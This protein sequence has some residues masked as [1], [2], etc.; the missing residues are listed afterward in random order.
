MKTII[1]LLCISLFLGS[2]T[3]YAQSLAVNTTGA[4]ANSSSILDVSSGSKGILIPRMSSVQRMGIGT[5]ANGL[6]VYDIDSSAFSY[7]NGAVWSFL[8]A[9]VDTA[10][11]WNTK[12]NN[13]ITPANFLGTV[14]DA[15]LFF[16]RNTINA[17]YIKS[18]NTAFGVLSGN[19]GTGTNNTAFGYANLG[20]NTTGSFNT[21][22]GARN[23]EYSTGDYN[24]AIGAFNLSKT[25]QAGQNY[26]KNVAIGYGAMQNQI[27][28]RSNI[29]IGEA[30]LNTDT[31]S[32]N[33]IAIGYKALFNNANK[34]NL[35]AIGDSALYN[36][37][38]GSASV[39][40][41]ADNT[42]LG[43]KTLSGNTIGYGNTAT[44]KSAL[45]ANINGGLNVA[46]GAYTLFFNT[47]GN[48]N[49]AVGSGAQYKN[50]TGNSNTAVGDGTL[51]QN[52]V[53]YSNVAIGISALYNNTT[54]S[55]LVAIGDSA[56][57]NNG[58]G[59][60]I[61]YDGAFNTAIGSKALFKNTTGNS[62]TATGN[63]SLYNNITGND[64]TANGVNALASNTIGASNTANGSSALVNNTNGNSNTANGSSALAGNT[65]GTSNTASGAGALLS[66]TSGNYNTANGVFSM[67]DNLTG[68]HNT[69]IGVNALYRNKR[70]NFNT[71]IGDSSLFTDTVSNNTALGAYTLAA[72]VRGTNNVAVGVK[73]GNDPAND[74]GYYNTYIGDSTMMLANRTNS[75]VIGSKA[76]TST[77]NSMVLGSING[78][79]GATADVKI[80]IGVTDP[81]EKLEIGNGRLRFRGNAPFGNAH[82]ITWTNNAGTTDR[83]FIGMETDNFWG[84]YSFG[85]G[86][87]VRVHNTTGE[88]GVF[89]QPLTTVNDSRLQVK[90][91]G[92]QNGIGIENTNTTNH[93]DL[94]L[95]AGAVP[96]FNF[97][98][99]GSLRS[100]IRNSDGAYIQ[101]SDK[102][103]KKDITVLQPALQKISTLQPYQYHYVENNAGSNYSI[104]FMAQ[105]VQ[106][107]FPDAVSEKLMKDGRLQLGVNYQY[108]TVLAIKGLQEQQSNMEAQNKKIEVLER[109]LAEL[110]KLVEQ[111]LKN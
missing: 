32:F 101:V 70:G 23:I 75:T 61:I 3:G 1:L 13:N 17:G 52:I 108:F 44:G 69:A 6:L 103:L 5:P 78:V 106:K 71:A 95:D 104:G 7:F 39:T 79:N 107:L 109:Q 57:Y 35:V 55:N 54:R 56:L 11:T 58:I 64:N 29:A 88:V 28:G 50:T 30:A 76:Y 105:D 111:S 22:L 15:D 46:N 65:T 72:N 67:V 77:N 92:S 21:A 66:N 4:T 14:N 2:I 96:D 41:G 8:K 80:G 42:A 84:I 10:T 47:A 45:N 63:N 40:Q 60:L 31:T 37:S 110:K 100:Y 12:G 102:N 73:A 26:T 24:V 74:N 48:R 85:L 87:N 59:A 98:L 9:G 43:S 99:N 27:Y 94:F 83:A 33:N 90:Q 51:Y 86:W 34:N 18:T 16:K 53:G 91:S 68:S 62:N 20:V 81:T 25:F 38:T 36:N 89:K 97:Y 49:T 93:W 82:G 19:A